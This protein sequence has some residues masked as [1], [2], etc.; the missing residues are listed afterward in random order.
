MTPP[1]GSQR[2]MDQCYRAQKWSKQSLSAAGLV[3]YSMT[4]SWLPR[5]LRPFA[6]GR[7]YM[8]HSE[9]VKTETR[10]EMASE[11]RRVCWY[12]NKTRLVLLHYCL[13]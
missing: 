5:Q 1:E 4:I 8:L 3:G 9:L 6:G 7:G 2:C 10:T 12:S 13:S 11:R